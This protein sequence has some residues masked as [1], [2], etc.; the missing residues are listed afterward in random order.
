MDSKLITGDPYFYAQQTFDKRLKET[1]DLFE[2][3]KVLTDS[4]NQSVPS[5][6]L[7]QYTR[8]LLSHLDDM[9]N[10]ISEL[11]RCMA[12]IEKNH[13]SSRFKGIDSDEMERRRKYLDDIKLIVHSIRDNM[14]KQRLTIRKEQKT[15]REDLLN[16]K[17]V[18]DEEHLAEQGRRYIKEQLVKEQ[19]EMI[20]QISSGVQR[21]NDMAHTIQDEIQQHDR[22]IDTVEIQVDVAQTKL[23]HNKRQ[24]ERIL[25]TN[26]WCQIKAII[27]LFI[28]A[29]FY[30]FY[31]LFLC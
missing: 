5:D 15:I 7:R 29:V 25:Q 28:V 24:V 16:D 13:D 6:Q 4:K 2:K 31:T 19:E 21:L 14:R 3:W 10:L 18:E 20:D 26:N 9:E 11:T 1:K 22:L 12:I 8:D 27:I 30:V 17:P 23:E